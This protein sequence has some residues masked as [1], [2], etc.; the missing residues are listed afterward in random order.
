MKLGF[1][2][3]IFP[4]DWGPRY[5]LIADS[6]IKLDL[7]IPLFKC[8]YY[9]IT[10]PY[11]RFSGDAETNWALEVVFELIERDG[12]CVIVHIETILVVICHYVCNF[13][14]V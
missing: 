6:H 10:L 14:F 11:W 1:T 3:T 5:E 13:S 4:G 2:I 8:K 7:A 12:V 9:L